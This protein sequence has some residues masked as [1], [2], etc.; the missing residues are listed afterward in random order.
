MT[1]SDDAKARRSALRQFSVDPGLAVD[2]EEMVPGYLKGPHLARARF[3]WAISELTRLFKMEQKQMLGTDNKQDQGSAEHGKPG[4][5]G[6][7]D[8]NDLQDDGPTSPIMNA[9]SAP[10]QERG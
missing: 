10:R 3:G 2:L 6:K 1:K 5:D 9:M 8:N 4:H 7:S